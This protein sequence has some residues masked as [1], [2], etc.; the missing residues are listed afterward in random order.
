MADDRAALIQAMFA[1]LRDGSGCEVAG[2]QLSGDRL[3]ERLREWIPA[4]VIVMRQCPGGKSVVIAA[5]HVSFD[6]WTQYYA[7]RLAKDLDCGEV[8]ARN[9]RDDDGGTMPASIGRHIHVNRPTESS[10]KGAAEHE[11]PRAHEA[12]AD[13]CAALAQADGGLPLKLLIELHGHHRTSA[14]EVATVGLSDEDAVKMQSAYK[15]IA[16]REGNVPVLAIEPLHALRFTASQA[17]SIGS[18]RPA[19]CARALHLE[20]P[21][22]CREH[23]QA[24]SRF[25]PLLAEWL[26]EC[27]HVLAATA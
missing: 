20:L 6:N 18:L 15:R 22:S 14:L 13:Y 25:R 19:I 12:F 5:P 8:I 7:N 24:R 1:A 4:E 11:T 17:K 16:E 3:R 23:E 10:R 9:F 26:G 21:R 27:V 2:E